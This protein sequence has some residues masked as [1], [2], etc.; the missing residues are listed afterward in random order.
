MQPGRDF[1]VELVVAPTDEVRT[2]VD[3]LERELATNYADDQRHGLKLHALFEPHIRFFIVRSGGEAVGCG[4]VALFRNFAELKRMYVRPQARGQGVADAL[5]ARLA[6]EAEKAGL[7]LLRLETGT[8]QRAAVRFYA[9]HGF[10]ICD[11]FEPYSSMPQN[12]IAT[13][14]FMEKRLSQM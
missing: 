3:E 14:V 5:I 4:G 13:S 11:A 10:T 7:F 1:S 8:F 2:L 9:R 12:A 6:L